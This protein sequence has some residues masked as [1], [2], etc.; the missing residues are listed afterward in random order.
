MFRSVDIVVYLIPMTNPWQEIKSR[1]GPIQFLDLTRFDLASA[2]RE[3]GNQVREQVWR[4]LERR[5][6]DIQPKRL[7]TRIGQ[8]RG[9]WSSLQRHLKSRI[10]A[11]ELRIAIT[12]YVNCLEAWSEG[13]ELAQFSHPILNAQ[14]TNGGSLAPYELA[15]VL[16]H[17]NVGCQTGMYRSESGSVQLWHTEEDA[18][19]RSGGRF[20]KLRI[21][22][23]RVGAGDRA[24][25]FHAFIYPD[26]M[27]GPSFSWRNDGYVQAVDTLLLYNPPRI[28]DGILTNVVCWLALRL[29]LTVS[30][31]DMLELLKPFFDGYAMNLI[32][33]E[34]QVVHATRYEF[35]GDRVIKSRLSNDP[36]SFLFQ[37]NYFSDR[38]DA[39]LQEMEALPKRSNRVMKKR[40]ERTIQVLQNHKALADRTGLQMRHFFRLVTS[41][42]GR[43]WAYANRDV[44]AY[45]L[46]Q[47]KQDAMEI[48][49]GAGPAGREDVPQ[50][51]TQKL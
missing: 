6:G 22:S 19:W 36:D 8:A 50:K 46:C 5:L 2:H 41:R 23:F 18:D 43:E 32:L 10:L 27:P 48:W 35:A 49:L 3:L 13:L 47:V 9:C 11:E 42:A 45:F 33:P 39:S 31:L 30:A 25:Q 15:L 17:D 12:D 1:L 21:A 28:N 4:I 44:K 38:V 14:V 37:V 40:V 26:L 51:I 20:D 24:D 34:N 16:Q 7:A 29:G